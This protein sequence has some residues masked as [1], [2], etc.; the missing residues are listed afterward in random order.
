MGRARP[1]TA[2]FQ[3]L[4]DPGLPPLEDRFHV[5]VGKIAHVSGQVVLEGGALGEVAEV[6]SLDH[7]LDADGGS[8][9][10][11]EIISQRVVSVGNLPVF[12]N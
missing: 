12:K 11:H 1:L 3:D 10:F 7:S 5:P 6:D 8:N 9:K 2:P 4:A